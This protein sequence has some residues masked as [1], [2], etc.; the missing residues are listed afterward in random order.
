MSEQT[1][2]H[3]KRE[4]AVCTL[5]IDNPEK[6]NT[7]TL[8][9]L[10][11]MAETF[12]RLARDEEVRTVVIRGAGDK[13]FSA[14][15]D[16]AA[17]TSRNDADLQS[18]QEKTHPFDKAMQSIGKYPYPIIAMLNGFAYGGGFELALT[19]D[20]RIAATHVKMGMPP[21]K[22]GLVYRYDG[23]KRFITVLGY[24]RTLELFLTARS[25]DSA[26]CLEMGIVNHVVP[27]DELE[28][29]AYD[30]AHEMTQLAPL[31]LRHSKYI[32]NKICEYPAISKEDLDKFE[33]LQMQAFMSDDH[34]EGKRAFIEKRKPQFKGR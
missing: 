31:S 4:D 10:I 16:I 21:A 25:Y 13:A 27:G 20:I 14:G 22:V 6:H 12:E 17:F 29:F 19:C 7:L 34:E 11:K 30:L 33:S 1:A 8:E 3:V 15:F 18:R 24:T 5:V 28:S 2:L 32:L 9:C 23:F 26:K